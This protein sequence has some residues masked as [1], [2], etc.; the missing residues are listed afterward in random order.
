M[1]KPKPVK[2]IPLS[3][4]CGNGVGVVLVKLKDGRGVWLPRYYKDGSDILNFVPGGVFVPTWLYN[5]LQGGHVS[6]ANN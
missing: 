6:S 2:F 1:P 4:V 3:D 5:K